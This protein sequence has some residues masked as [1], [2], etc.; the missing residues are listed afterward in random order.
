VLCCAK[1]LTCRA[2]GPS[3]WAKLLSGSGG[4]RVSWYISSPH[5]I[6]G[7][8]SALFTHSFYT[9]VMPDANKEMT[10]LHYRFIEDSVFNHPTY[11]SPQ[12]P[13]S[14]IHGIRCV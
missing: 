8:M 3:C 1:G 10:P 2:D 12:C 11:P 13:I 6:Y 5:F 4:K 14:I 9:K 7:I